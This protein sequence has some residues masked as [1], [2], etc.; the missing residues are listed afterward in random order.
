M[1]DTTE[2]TDQPAF[3][4]SNILEA[5]QAIH[6]PKS[7]NFFRRNASD[8]LE[9]LKTSKESALQCGFS[10]STDQS[11][12]ALVQHFGLSL[13]SHV[14]RHETHHLSE[15][16]AIQLR[17]CVLDLGRSVK[18]EH[19]AFIRN[20]VAELWIELAKRSWA[21]DWFD[22]DEQLAQLWSQG[23]VHK[24]IVLTILE[25]LS[26]DV[27]VRD[28]SIA[29][30]RGRDLNSALVEIF[31]PSSNFSGGIKIGGITHNLRFGDEGWLTRITRL[32]NESV[33]NLHNDGQLREVVLK[34]LATLRSC[35]IWV[36]TPAI[37]QSNALEATCN[38]LTS[39]D[40]DLIIAA[41]DAL[42]SL[43][44]RARLEELE[45]QALVFPLVHPDSIAM[46]GKLYVWSVVPVDE[47]ES[48]KYVVS[49]KL[50]ELL[51]LFGDHMY[52]YTPPTAVI[53]DLSPFLQLLTAVA[54]HESLIVSIPVIHA[55]V[56]M[57]EVSSWRANPA[58]VR[59]M[60][61]LLQVVSTRLIQYEQFPEDVQNPVVTFVNEEIELFP[62]RQGFYMNY[63]RLCAAA[64]EWIAFAG[65][66]A[67][68]FGTL[69]HVDAVLDE[70]ES[71]EQQFDAAR[72]E[73]VSMAILQADAYLSWVDAAF[74][75]FDRFQDEQR[76]SLTSEHEQMRQRIRENLKAWML[77]T[78][79]KRVFKDPQIRQR[80]IKTAVDASYR[81]LQKDTGFAFR[82]LEHILSSFITMPQQNPVYAE[83]VDDLH[84]YATAELRRLSLQH[85]DYFV[86]FYDQL[87]SK[88]SD[89]IS[90]IGANERLQI[91]LKSIL[92]SVIQ[93]A[94]SVDDAR[95]R[96]KLGEFVQPLAAAWADQ[97]LQGL[98]GSLES[99]AHSQAFDQVGP[100]LATLQADRIED[101]SQVRYD[102]RGSEIQQEML[103]GYT[104]LP[105]RETRILLSISTE[106]LEQGSDLHK[107]VCDLWSPMV[108][109]MLEY[110]LRLTSFNHQLHN[111]SSWPNVPPEG[112]N[113]IRRVMRDRYW[114]SGISAGSMGEF[115]NKVKAT[116]LTLEG[117]ASSVRGRIRNNLEQCYSILHTLG[118][119]GPAFYNLQQ[120]PELIAQAAI[121]TTTPLSP[122]HFSVMIQ[123]LPKMID[124]C[125]PESREQ[126]LTPI[127]WSL[128]GQM[129]TKLSQEWEKMGQLKQTKHD[130]ENLGDEMRDDS[131][132]R[133]TTYKA[134]NLIA[135]WLN[136]KREQQLSTK[137]S[138]VNG[139][140]LKEADQQTMREFLLSNV[141]ILDKLLTFITHAIAFKDMKSSYTMLMAVQR[142]VPDF[143]SEQFLASDQAGAVREFISTEM[144]KTAITCL[145]DGYFA[146]QQQY[147]AQL[148][149]TI[150]LS[151][152]LPAHVPATEGT[153][154]HDR[155]ALTSTPRDV[156]MSLPGMT[157]AKVD[158]AA[159]QL[160][161]E[162][163][164]GS[165]RAKK[166]RAII[167]TLLEGVRGVRVSELGK[168]D[169][170]QQQS[171]LLEKYKQREM[172]GMQGVE[173]HGHGRQDGTAETDLAGVADMF[174]T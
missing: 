134:V 38:F 168:I 122:H 108:P 165:S 78:M 62:E 7:D 100:Y 141:Q 21:L 106:R 96:A 75:G 27:F 30:L 151:Y 90:Q 116:K 73:R 154:A 145:H 87:Q 77:S 25:N 112:E 36:M 119:L 10:L 47:I 29:V 136:P 121:D 67:A 158:K 114:Q 53:F 56:K 123:M 161:K 1:T 153:P 37:S 93:R 92:F 126:F 54:E 85:A 60:G 86:T 46:L 150:W 174:A 57:L 109:N 84:S 52:Q 117:F 2:S 82:V 23:L 160:L 130:D 26:E 128:L 70:I 28:D 133:Q 51:S 13:L 16:Q 81:V 142:L 32:I 149:A 33:G 64:I 127:L 49:K 129:D 44:G 166:L 148:I 111:P 99:F 132:L 59:C 4:R 139:S 163:A 71:A 88:F 105:L 18:A 14:I 146:D 169:T 69:G 172:L 89:L 83:A 55:W 66:E 40:T 156:I 113:I 63:R 76:H 152:G 110:V 24:D 164:G 8:Y 140:Y 98:L 170:K 157:E 103:S 125:P 79:E 94:T 43:Y 162:G 9:R 34:A 19:L 50:S 138:I 115:H 97:S 144:L 173:D 5:L 137:K 42:L 22:L 124:E 120:L 12:P 65:P 147:Y 135:H 31:T 61:P 48:P 45:V 107:M 80:L 17:N 72:Y 159:G 39:S 6:D 35:F 3:D 95:R 20:K 41:L 167:L 118:R 74:K 102:S 101:W 91:D 15:H 171:K 155:H 68:I 104:R 143:A 131:V 11:Q 58:I